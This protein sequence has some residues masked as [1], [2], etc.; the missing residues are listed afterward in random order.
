MEG[1][2]TETTPRDC[3]AHPLVLA[4]CMMLLGLL[5]LALPRCTAEERCLG[6]RHRH[7]HHGHKMQILSEPYCLKSCAGII[8][9]DEEKKPQPAPPAKPA[10]QPHSQ[11]VSESRCLF[12]LSQEESGLARCGPSLFPQ[13]YLR[14]NRICSRQLAEKIQSASVKG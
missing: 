4:V 14:P 7:E 13:P 12:V 5:Y 3:E 2:L 8:L 1:A 6:E 10:S 11:S 9:R